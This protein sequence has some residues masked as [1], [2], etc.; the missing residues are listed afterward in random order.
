MASELYTP[1]EHSEIRLL[2]F[3]SSDPASSTNSYKLR[4]VPLTDSVQFVALSYVWGT[5][6]ATQSIMINDQQVKIR[7]NLYAALCQLQS[8]GFDEH[9]WCDALCINQRD[10]G[11]KNLQVPRMG[12]VYTRAKRVIIW[13]GEA[14]WGSEMAMRNIRDWGLFYAHSSEATDSIFQDKL[15]NIFDNAAWNATH[16]LLARNWW[17]RIWVLQEVAVSRS[18]VLKCGASNCEWDLLACARASWDRLMEPLILKYLS[19]DQVGKLPPLRPDVEAAAINFQ[20]LRRSATATSLLDLLQNTCDFNAT[21]PRDKIYALMGLQPTMDIAIVPRYEDPVSKVYIDFA[22]A[23]AMGKCRLSFLAGAGIGSPRPKPHIDLPS[24]VPDLRGRLP[25]IANYSSS[26]T[27]SSKDANFTFSANSRQLFAKGMIRDTIKQLEVQSV[28]D[29]LGRSSWVDLVLSQTGSFYP[30]GMIRLQAYFR[31][32]IGDT[33]NHACHYEDFPDSKSADDFYCLTV[34]FLYILVASVL[35]GSKVKHNTSRIPG[36][37]MNQLVDFNNYVKAYAQ[38]DGFITNPVSEEGI[39]ET[40]LGA[41]GS[42][43]QLHWPHIKDQQLGQ[44]CL[45]LLAKAMSALCINNSSFF[46]TNDGYMG[47]APP[48]TLAGDQV[49]VLL[50]CEVPLVIR[51]HEGQYLLVGS[52]YVYRMMHG[53]IL[54][55][56]KLQIQEIALR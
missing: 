7:P 18:A 36:D 1:L 52:C 5:D 24:W 10:T 41:R 53:E 56:S 33:S 4:K 37:S 43:Y 22:R 50:G 51:R 13:L 6:P 55:D 32:I 25:M 27:G 15:G 2:T 48:G 34:G 35:D 14:R 45:M 47:L 44:N 8:E 21:D 46:I 49:C 39:L 26:A 29:T 19:S 23:F 16:S 40:F 20:A 3:P 30:T 12:E 28:D 54:E 38:W 31:T 9:L 42:K 11:E 17:F